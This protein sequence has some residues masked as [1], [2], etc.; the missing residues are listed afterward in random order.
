VSDEKEDKPGKKAVKDEGEHRSAQ[1]I[2]TDPDPGPTCPVLLNPAEWDDPPECTTISE[3]HK[4]ETTAGIGPDSEDPDLEA[5]LDH[6]KLRQ[7]QKVMSEYHQEGAPYLEELPGPTKPIEPEDEEP[8][9]V[10]KPK[11]KVV[12]KVPTIKEEPEEEIDIEKEIHLRTPTFHEEPIEPERP[13][14]GPKEEPKRPPKRVKPETTPMHLKTQELIPSPY[15]APPYEPKTS[16]PKPKLPHM[17]S[18][19]DVKQRLERVLD[20]RTLEFLAYTVI[21]TVLPRRVRYS[22][23]KE[24]IVDMDIV[25]FDRDVILN[26]NKL[27][28]E[29]PELAIWRIVYAYKGKAVI[30]F[31]RGVKNN[32]KIYKWRLMRILIQLWWSKRFGKAKRQA[33]ED[34]KEEDELEE[35]V[36]LVA[37]HNARKAARRLKAKQKLRKTS[38]SSSE[39]E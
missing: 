22:V 32:I 24:G 7:S 31:G 28:F 20:V 36:D 8:P 1:V 12:K 25:L 37:V 4:G 27:E 39:E 11:V 5:W 18:E 38:K 33:K 17:P 19:T 2:N 30:E 9:V 34:K 21:R 14:P 16:K 23:K 26:T 15:A 10:E 29:V 13:V 6:W 35:E 3:F